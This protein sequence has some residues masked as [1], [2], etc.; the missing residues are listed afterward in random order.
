[1]KTSAKV[2]A[3]LGVAVSKFHILYNKLSVFPQQGGQLPNLRC[4][5]YVGTQCTL[6]Y[7]QSVSRWI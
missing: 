6:L 2:A 3:A 7:K 1:L 5:K 4:G